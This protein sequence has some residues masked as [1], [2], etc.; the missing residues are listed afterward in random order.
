MAPSVRKTF[1]AKTSDQNPLLV[2][3]LFK[4]DRSEGEL[5][6]SWSVCVEAAAASVF[7]ERKAKTQLLFSLSFLESRSAWN[8]SSREFRWCFFGNA[9]ASDVSRWRTATPPPNP[10]LSPA[11]SPPSSPLQDFVARA[12]SPLKQ[13]LEALQTR[14]LL[15][16]LPHSAVS[17]ACGRHLGWQ[18]RIR[19]K[20]HLERA[21]WMSGGRAVMSPLNVQRGAGNIKCRPYRR[22]LASHNPSRGR[23]VKAIHNSSARPPR[24][25]QVVQH[26]AHFKAAWVQRLWLHVWREYNRPLFFTRH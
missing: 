8:V 5:K 6:A 17:S 26:G 4:C 3:V 22:A 9:A 24:S 1:W 19:A 20:K 10:S 12:F 16:P 2:A 14:H 15:L 13:P 21:G 18:E 7:S 25:P 11:P 23:R